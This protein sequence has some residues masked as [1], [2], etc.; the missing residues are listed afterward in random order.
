MKKILNLLFAAVVMASAMVSCGGSGG[1]DNPGPENLV[2]AADVA[3]IV[4][5]GVDKVT[6]TVTY[7]G[8]NV[9]SLAVIKRNGMPITGA[10]FTS[11]TEGEYTFTAEYDGKTSNTVAIM[12]TPVV[13][14]GGDLRITSDKI[15]MLSDEVDKIV[16]RATYDGVDV[17]EDAVFGTVDGTITLDG[18]EFLYD[19]AGVYR[20]VAK[21][22]GVT[23]SYLSVR[24]DDYPAIKLY[25]TKYYLGGG[26]STTFTVM[27]GEE[28]ITDICSFRVVG[29]STD[30]PGNTFSTSE[31]GYHE[32]YA[33]MNNLPP[34]SHN[35]RESNATKVYVMPTTDPAAAFDAT[36]TP[37]K[38]VGSFLLTGWWCIACLTTEYYM[39]QLE[40]EIT[41]HIISVFFYDQKDEN[42]AA[43]EN[44]PL[45][46]RTIFAKIFQ[47]VKDY[48]RISS[49]GYPT[50]VVDWDYPEFA[51]GSVGAARNRYNPRINQPAKAGIKVSSELSSN[52][53]SVDCTVTVGAKQAGKYWVNA[54]LV[55]DNIPWVQLSLQSSTKPETNFNHTNVY[56]NMAATS[57]RGVEVGTFTVGQEMSKALSIP[58]KPNYNKGQLSLV[59]YVLYERSGSKIVTNVVKVPVDGAT[60]YIYED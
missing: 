48:Y 36:K 1:G 25:S 50:Y 31:T 54:I 40:P 46:N 9:T 53:Q 52:G 16:F 55:E 34:T 28:D 49:M 24:V 12:V 43:V 51:L 23:S 58:V 10:Q 47:E 14:G 39:H 22:D 29:S 19:R 17:T 18:A 38:N 57:V 56:R 15:I 27:M 42:N 45:C 7:N 13:S 4:N 26:A 44:T 30:L 21:Y 32:V 60:G 41:D 59:V 8:E 37:Y 5:N 33:Y 11:T 3:T 35:Y 20:F 6:F 2:L